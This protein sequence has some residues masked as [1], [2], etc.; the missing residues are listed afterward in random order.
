MLYDERL[1]KL[2]EKRVALTFKEISKALGCN[3]KTFVRFLKR[4]EFYSSINKNGK[5]YILLKV[6]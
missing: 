6:G 5:Y 1:I 2:F 4:Q 3:Y